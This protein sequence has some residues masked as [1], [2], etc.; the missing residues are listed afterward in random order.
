MAGISPIAEEAT[1]F[2][3][4]NHNSYTSNKLENPAAAVE[5]N[6]T[7]DALTPVMVVC[8]TAPPVRRF[9]AATPAAVTMDTT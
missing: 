7:N 9:E 2:A 3:R 5:V 1:V 4:D 8:A 6:A